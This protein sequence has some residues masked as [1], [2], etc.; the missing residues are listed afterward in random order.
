MKEKSVGQKHK[1]EV[2]DYQKTQ[3]AEMKDYKSRWLH[4]KD[5]GKGSV[6]P[7]SAFDK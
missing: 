1:S 6:R 2:K 5:W 3:K 4:A 7:G